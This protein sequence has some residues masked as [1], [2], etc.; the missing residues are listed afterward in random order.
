M[1]TYIISF[2]DKKGKRRTWKCV[3][4]TGKE[5]KQKFFN[6]M[7]GKNFVVISVTVVN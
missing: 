1:H 6:K 7:D 5:A 3:A 2:F 4:E